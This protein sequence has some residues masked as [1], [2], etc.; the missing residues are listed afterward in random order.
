MSGCLLGR[1]RAGWPPPPP[2]PTSYFIQ[3]VFL[4]SWFVVVSSLRTP[5]RSHGYASPDLRQLDLLLH[6]SV[7]DRRQIPTADTGEATRVDIEFYI[8]SFSSVNPKHMDYSVDLSLRQRWSEARLN[9]TLRKPIDTHDPMVV[10][11]LWKP[12][13]YFPNAKHGDFQYVT[14]PNVLVRIQPNGA[15]LYILRM[16]L[17]FSCVMDLSTFP[18]D[19]QT[20]YME[21]ASFVKTT[22]ELHLSWYHDKP[23]KLYRQ[24]HLL[25]FDVQFVTATNCSHSFLAG[26][27][28][29]LQ[30]VFHLQRNV[31]YHL[32]QSY[33]PSSL[34]VV[35]SWIS[36]WLDADA[37]ASRVILGVTTLFTVCSESAAFG[38][39][40]PN[41][42]YVKALDVWMGACTV[43]V[44]LAMVEFTIV[45]YIGR[46]RRRLLFRSAA[47][48]DQTKLVAQER[49]ESI[50][51]TTVGTPEMAGSTAGKG[52]RAMIPSDN[53]NTEESAAA[54][55]EIP[56]AWLREAER[57][58]KIDRNSRVIFP[59]LFL[60]F[61]LGYWIYYQVL[62]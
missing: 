28:S 58:K 20:C 34:I 13:V 15:I 25:Q 21:V 8:R 40:L 48:A 18:M 50:C 6:P 49:R 45:N 46:R 31:G 27:Y 14:V 56:L 10:K 24:L 42:S 32:V 41:V 37:V 9:N 60:A 43:F 47:A 26:N 7:Y 36:F 16:K 17:T 39:K 35:V 38:N 22:R 3:A 19:H 5:S 29:C 51:S 55:I 52:D 44:F 30:A 12:E 54:N 23:V 11:L 1:E 61:N 33:L 57:A 4:L 2:P 62:C 59:L 53:P